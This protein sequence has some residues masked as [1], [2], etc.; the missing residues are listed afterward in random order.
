MS[1]AYHMVIFSY[2]LNHS[3]D[4]VYSDDAANECCLNAGARSTNELAI[5]Y[6]WTNVATPPLPGKSDSMLLPPFLVKI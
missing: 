5:L 1:L 3:W 4:F 6:T 2:M